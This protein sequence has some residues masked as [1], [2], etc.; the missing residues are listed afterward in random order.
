MKVKKLNN[1]INSL[2]IEWI[3]NVL[4]DKEK[5]KVTKNNIKNLLSKQEYLQ[6]NKTFYLS[7]YTPRWAKQ[8]IKKLLRKGYSLD[9]ITMKDLEDLT[10]INISRSESLL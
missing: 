8:N 7:M 3:Q 2:L 4:S 1:K 10:R 5:N 9:K 6:V